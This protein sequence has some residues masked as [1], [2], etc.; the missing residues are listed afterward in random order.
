MIN[1]VLNT[2]LIKNYGIYGAAA[3]TAITQFLSLT[4]SN[5]FFKKDGRE[6]FK[7]QIMALNPLE[8]L[9]NYRK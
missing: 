4:V 6:V 7:W 9:P 3:A 1:I 5:L 8:M 2:V